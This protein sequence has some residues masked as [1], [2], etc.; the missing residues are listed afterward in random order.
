[1]N[2]TKLINPQHQSPLFSLPSELREKIFAANKSVAQVIELTC[3]QGRSDL[4]VLVQPSEIKNKQ[5]VWSVLRMRDLNGV[6]F[7]IDEPMSAKSLYGIALARK[8]VNVAQEEYENSKI[9]GQEFL[10]VMIR[11]VTKGAKIGFI[12]YDIVE[13]RQSL[14][15]LLAISALSMRLLRSL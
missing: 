3:R 9:S 2:E 1:M 12:D 5:D 14:S 6:S 7:F 4:D 8:K 15:A 10:D 11:A 13:K